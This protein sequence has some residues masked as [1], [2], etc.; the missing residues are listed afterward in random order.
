MDFMGRFHKS[1]EEN[2][3]CDSL[4]FLSKNRNL[5]D[6]KP[7]WDKIFAD[8]KIVASTLDDTY[9]VMHAYY[10][11]AKLCNDNNIILIAV[12]PP[13]YK[14][15]LEQI[16]QKQIYHHHYVLESIKKKY[17]TSFEFYDY[18]FDKRFNSDDFQDAVHLNNNGAK[19][20]SLIVK[21]EILKL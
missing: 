5:K 10:D 18:T 2:R 15:K 20:F 12:A 21:K 14:T 19:K 9:S 4:G 1:D 6:R 17:P 7:G 16:P 3:L 8:N 13:Y 11:I